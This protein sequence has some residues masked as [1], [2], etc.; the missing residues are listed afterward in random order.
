LEPNYFLENKNSLAIVAKLM[1][2]GVK[3]DNVG[4]GQPR[5]QTPIVGMELAQGGH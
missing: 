1:N 2:E 4:S 5:S 3:I